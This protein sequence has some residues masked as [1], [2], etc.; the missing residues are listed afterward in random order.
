MLRLIGAAVLIYV[1]LQVLLTLAWVLH[2]ALAQ[3]EEGRYF[4]EQELQEQAFGTAPATVVT[5]A[6]GNADDAR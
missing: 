5:D 1:G 2:I 6:G 3:P 4:L